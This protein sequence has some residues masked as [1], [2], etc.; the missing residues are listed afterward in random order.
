M[1]A[2]MAPLVTQ[3]SRGVSIKDANNAAIGAILAII[4]AIDAAF[5]AINAASAAINTN[6][7]AN[8]AANNPPIAFHL[9]PID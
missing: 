7:A 4:E 8:N 5:G 1:L 3:Y 2:L 9:L 6:N